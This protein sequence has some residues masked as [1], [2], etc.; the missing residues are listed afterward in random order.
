MEKLKFE[1]DEQN[2]T[3]TIEGIKYSGEIFRQLGGMLEVG[4]LFQL[5]ER[6]NGVLTIY[7]A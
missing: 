5:M 6:E 1:Y 7:K 2:D 4:A 3:I